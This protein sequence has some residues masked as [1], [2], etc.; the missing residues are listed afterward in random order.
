MANSLERELAGP[1]TC[2]SCK[3]VR[4]DVERIERNE[5][6]AGGTVH[7]LCRRCGLRFVRVFA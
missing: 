1:P 4:M 5:L 3:N 6:T 2:P 7:W